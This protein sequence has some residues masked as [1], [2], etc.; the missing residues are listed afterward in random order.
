MFC[1][2]CGKQIDDDSNFCSY[3]GTK[4]T[5]I[6]NPVVVTTSEAK[7]AY[8]NLSFDKPTAKSPSVEKIKKEKYDLSYQ[9]ETDATGAGAL[10]LI[11]SLCFLL[12]GGVKDPSLYV[13]V[14]LILFIIRIIIT[15]W[16]VNIA[17][18]QNRETIAWGFFAFFLPSIALIIIG[19]LRK[20][21]KGTGNLISD[22][23]NS[24]KKI[25]H[26]FNDL[27]V[28]ELP[29]PSPFIIDLL[30]KDNLMLK[31]FIKEYSRY[32]REAN[33]LLPMY[34]CLELNKRGEHFNDEIIQSISAY[35]TEQGFSS[36]N[37]M[38]EHYNQKVKQ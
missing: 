3:C 29:V 18:R 36:I 7:T 25:I 15:V 1:K 23:E 8:G 10:L 11:V 12:F 4:Q 14:V 35:S 9:K 38:L 30:K 32:M 6:S 31:R 2:A 37:E 33:A 21:K 20:L 19:Q 34:A 16:C 17:A 22:N 5:A 27:S 24:T 26:V 13:V 28:V